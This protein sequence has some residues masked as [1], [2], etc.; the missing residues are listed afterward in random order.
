MKRKNYRRQDR[1]T[2]SGARGNENNKAESWKDGGK[3][4]MSLR[5]H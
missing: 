4:S 2:E 5:I 1:D 3:M